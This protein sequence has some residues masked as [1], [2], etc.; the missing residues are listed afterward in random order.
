MDSGDPGVSPTPPLTSQVTSST[1]LHPSQPLSYL[2]WHGGVYLPCMAGRDHES[3]AQPC[4]EGAGLSGQKASLTS[5]GL[6]QEQRP[7]GAKD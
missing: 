4:L 6:T 5:L 2:P 7:H 1:S 3:L